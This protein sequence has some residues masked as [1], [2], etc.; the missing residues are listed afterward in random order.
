[1][2]GFWLG[3]VVGIAGTSVIGVFVMLGVSS[4]IKES[5][6]RGLGW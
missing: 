3:L 2:I 5:I 6:G 1:M 4:G